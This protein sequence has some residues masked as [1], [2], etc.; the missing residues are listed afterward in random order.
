[1]RLKQSNGKST[2]SGD[3]VEKHRAGSSTDKNSGGKDPRIDDLLHSSSLKK[4]KKR[5]RK[6]KIYTDTIPP[7]PQFETSEDEKENRRRNRWKHEKSMKTPR[8]RRDK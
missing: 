5:D 2:G 7:I 8:Q 6:K 3:T 4:K 1:M